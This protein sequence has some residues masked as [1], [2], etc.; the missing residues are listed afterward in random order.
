M[1]VYG[2][3][4]ISRDEDKENYDAIITQNKIINEYSITEIGYKVVRIFEDD[5]ISGY[6]FIRPGLDELKALIEAG[7]VDILLMKDLS[8]LG[9]HNAKTLL[10]LE[11]L[12]EYD[13]R[14]IL[15]NDNY[16]SSTDDDDIIG[17]KTWYNERYIKDISRK[18]K[19]NLKM[20]QKTDGLITKVY[21]GYERDPDNKHGLIID[22]E[23]ASIVQKIFQLYIAGNGGRIIAN[24]LQDEG[25]PTPSRYQY[26]KTGKMISGS[27]ADTWTGT[28]VMRIIKNDVYIG[29]LRCGKTERK[30]IN[31]KTERLKEELH[32]VH[33]EHH[34]PIISKKDFFLAQKILSNRLD[35]SVRGTS[36][37]INL[38]I[39]F[40]K[41]GDCGGGFMKVTKKRSPPSY[42]CTNNHHYG[43]SFCSSHKI[44]E[45]QLKII[46]LD[47]LKLMKSYIENTADELDKEI[48]S[49]VHLKVNHEQSIKQ[50][51]I[52][53][54]DKKEE[55]KNYSKQLA[56]E[57]I[58][59]EIAAEVIKEANRELVRLESQL[60]E[61][62][63]IKEDSSNIKEKVFKSLD[64][65]NDIIESGDITRRNLEKLI[66]KI[67][68]KQ[69]NKSSPGVKPLLNIDIEWDVFISSIYDD[70]NI[71]NHQ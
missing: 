39:G 14:L 61:M 63:K 54:K 52:K 16:D 20:K 65:I 26:N 21:F 60:N 10:F 70:L 36:K 57:I 7:Q 15:I 19:S 41:C 13:V 47:K 67:T 56:K 11:Y 51:N 37:G 49:M 33:E 18:I 29:I 3:S 12:E 34:D 30:K 64:I 9:R 43:A 31:G 69:L 62:I 23:A 48:N 22:E 44:H 28:H 66:R 42:I 53:I 46:I 8:R 50:Y 38:F 32:I 55:I 58:S 59:E 25:I 27:I 45:E 1:K 68:I 4:R 6:T 40:L 35:N 24:I 2:Y 5:N 17:I 71:Q